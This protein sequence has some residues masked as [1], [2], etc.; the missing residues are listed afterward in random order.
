MKLASL[1][2]DV[3]SWQM[4]LL[5]NV[6]IMMFA[7]PEMVIRK[8]SPLGPPDRGVRFKLGLQAVIA[9]V[10]ILCYYEAMMRLELGDFGAISFSSPV[11]TMILSVFI[12]KDKCGI[13]RVL[14]SIILM[15]G[16]VVISRP[17]ALFGRESM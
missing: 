12:I 9:S 2:A 3:S 15:F 6:V 4:L 13:Y 7:L 17:P 8:V 16:V 11:F 10:L 1:R 14:V 5:R